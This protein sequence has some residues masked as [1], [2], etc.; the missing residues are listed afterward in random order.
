[1]NKRVY[2]IIPVY[3]SYNYLK[4]CLD[5]LLRQ[6]YDNIKIICVNDG[7]TDNSTCL[8]HKYKKMSNIIIVDQENRGVSSARNTGLDLL[9][10]DEDA[11]ITFVDSDDWVDHNYISTL[12]EI[13]EKYNVDI[14]SSS[15]YFYKCGKDTRLFLNTE[16]E[17]VYDSLDA[18]KLLIKDETI[19]SHSYSKLYKLCLWKNYRF[20]NDLFYMEDQDIVYKV[21][22]KSNAI[23][24]SNYSGY[25]YRQDNIQSITKQEIGTKKVV[26]G[27]RGY[28]SPCIYNYAEKDKSILLF[29]ANDALASAYLMLLPYYKSKEANSNEKYF[30]KIIKKYIRNNDVI[31]RYKPQDRNGKMKRRVYLLFP[32]FY[33]FI[34]R[35]Y[36]RITHR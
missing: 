23:Y 18:T 29:A 28:Y 33:P 26:S 25:H 9:N 24:I 11:Y 10:Y 16:R 17:G 32:F 36:K 21:F 1:M 22:Y 19:Q 7:S 13:M 4:K 12:V 34:F 31:Q 27:L 35:L 20:D 14:V 3:N 15:F 8:L 5:S 6:T 30:I 2:I